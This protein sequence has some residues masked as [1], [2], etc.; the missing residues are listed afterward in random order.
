MVH[1]KTMSTGRTKM[2]RTERRRPLGSCHTT[3]SPDSIE[4]NKGR[5]DCGSLFAD[6]AVPS[7]PLELSLLVLLVPEKHKQPD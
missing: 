7:P 1:M 3:C 6:D 2:N 5:S 4:S